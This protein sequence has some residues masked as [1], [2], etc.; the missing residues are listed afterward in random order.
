MSTESD[1]ET[2]RAQGRRLKAARE[3]WNLKYA[4]DG[5]SFL[6]E[7]ETT[8]S[9]H[10]NGTRGIS[11]N[12]ARKYAEHYDVPIEWILEGSNPPHWAIGSS[13]LSEEERLGPAEHFLRAWRLH[14]KITV[15]DLADRLKAPIDLVEGWESGTTDI[16]GKWLRKLADL[17]G[18]TPGAILDVD[19]GATAPDLLEL[20]LDTART[21]AS[22]RARI[23]SLR[24]TGTEG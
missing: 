4:K 11:K 8:Y 15:K 7:N 14:K 12:K 6:K 24:R 21:Q 2:Q 18:T 13:E 10:E 3:R 5:A 19:P 23:D 9:Q 17:L 20:W 22:M 16:S 1:R